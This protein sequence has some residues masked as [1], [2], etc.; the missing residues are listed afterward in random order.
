M[1]LEQ[2]QQNFTEQ[3]ISNHSWRQQNHIWSKEE[4]EER[5]ANITK[6]VPQRPSDYVMNGA[7]KVMYHGFNFITGYK[8]EDPSHESIEWRLI[9]L[10]SFAGVRECQASW[11]LDSGTFTLFVTCKG[12]MA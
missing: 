7:M 11:L 12:I 8:H 6:H 5:R 9:I 1:L 3:Q 2:Q 10:E 4:V